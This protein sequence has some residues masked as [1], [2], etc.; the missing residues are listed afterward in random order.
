[1]AHFQPRTRITF[2]LVLVMRIILVIALD[3]T[4]FL[5]GFVLVTKSKIPLRYP[6]R[7]QVRGW[8]QTFSE[9]E[10][11]LSLAASYHELASLRQVCDQP[12]TCLR[13]G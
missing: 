7:R 9:L 8:S 5:L 13:P 4:I 3:V 6:G 11:G 2:I 10:F 12:R 1:M